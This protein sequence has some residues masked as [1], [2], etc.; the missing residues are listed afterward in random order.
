M[1][2]IL[3]KDC[4]HCHVD[5]FRLMDLFKLEYFHPSQCRNCGGLIR[6]SGW[7]QFLGPA[8]TLVWLI[9]LALGSTFLPQWLVISILIFTVPLP[10]LILAKP[11][12]ADTPRIDFPPYTLDPHNDKSIVVKGWNEAEL[13]KILDGFIAQG[14]FATPFRMVLSKR[15]EEEFRLTFPEDIP[16]FDYLALINYLNYPI[17]VD[18]A[19]RSIAV[20]GKTTLTSDF[21][22]ITQ[23]LVGKKAMIYVPDRDENYDVVMLTAETG[24]TLRYSFSE[25]VWQFANGARMAPEVKMLS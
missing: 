12:K 5:A 21:H 2:A 14:E 1:A 19:G 25:Q 13:R 18:A 23:S 20:L 15:F 6:N 9:T 22:G 17:D 3:N 11:M 4:P 16:P 7:S 24:R 10:I 8:I